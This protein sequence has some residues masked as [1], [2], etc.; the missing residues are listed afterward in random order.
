MLN[1]REQLGQMVK[2]HR[3]HH[4]WTQDELVGKLAKANRSIVAHLE[5]GLRVPKPDVL[6]EICQL[7][8]IPKQYWDAF[9]VEESVQ[10]FEFEEALS[11]L[12]GYSV[13]LDGHD[14]PSRAV[15]ERQIDQLFSDAGSEGQTF[16]RVNSILVYYGARP[17]RREFFAR[18]FGAPTFGSVATFDTAVKDYQKEAIRLFSTLAEAFRQLNR[19][20]ALEQLLKPLEPHGLEPYSDRTEWDSIEEIEDHRLPDL[21]Y[22]SAA[23]IKQEAAERE[24]LKRFLESLAKLIRKEGKTA[25]EK[26][27]TK[28]R[29]RM[30][31]LL[32]KFRSTLQHGLFSPLFAPDPDELE[33]EAARLA[34]K[35]AGE[36]TRMAATQSTAMRNLA[37]YLSAD[38]MDIYVATS[39]R[40]DA[41]FVSV[42]HFV[43]TLFNHDNVRPLKLRYFNPTQSWIEDR[44]AKG[45]VE[46]LMLRRAEVTIYMAQ[47]SDT[48]GK[49]SEASVALGQGKPVIVYVPKLAFG[50][51][52]TAI[53]TEKLFLKDRAELIGM[54]DPSDKQDIDEGVDEQ[55]LVSRILNSKLEATS[56][57]DLGLTALAIWADFDLHNE[58]DRISDPSLKAEYRNWLDA[59][60]QDK[61]FEGDFTKI[62][63]H[64]IGILVANA[65]RFEARAKVFREIHPLALQVILSSGVLNGI[66]VVRSGEQ[67]AAV[68]AALIKNELRL[69]LKKDEHNYRLV[70][71]LTASTIRVISRHRLLRHAFQNFYGR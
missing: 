65:I 49:D 51:G 47:K 70:E 37:R 60:I 35:T 66:L 3:E 40:S 62:R 20:D 23:R 10:R 55:A 30:D 22:I 16:D 19:P 8:G 4:G 44:V 69:E 39:M 2:S 43:R 57:E 9:T 25:L 38:H 53:D 12:L 59:L 68:L 54:L 41:D 34:P 24:A 33:R 28:T 18:Y 63:G 5:Q 14:P 13:T 52:A 21:G 64:V 29:R 17:V 15:A 31:S 48:F 1:S 61:T 50:E 67:C 45:L 7:L 6:S 42:N 11:E 36:L 56:D 27:A 32:R 46:A 58:A 71:E 26:I